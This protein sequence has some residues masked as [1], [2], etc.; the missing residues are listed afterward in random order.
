MENATLMAHRGANLMTRD[1]LAL[2]EAPAATDTHRP[3]P[4]ID[5]V[6]EIETTLALRRITIIEERFAVS[7]DGM[8]MFGLLKLET[9]FT[10]GNFAIGVR[11]SNDKSMRL[12]MVAGY[13]VFVCDNMAFVGEFQPVM[14]KH[15]KHVEITDTVTLGI[16]RIQRHFDP[17]QKQVT[18]WKDRA[19]PDQYAKAM[20]YDAFTSPK[21]RLPKQLLPVVDRHYF[22]PQYEEFAGRNM[23]SI[24]NAFTSAFK[25]LNPVRMFQDTAKLQPFLAQYQPPF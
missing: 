1:A 22:K 18:E 24:S 2:V 3:I 7:P 12:A 11:N 21:L 6:K 4:H 16:D 19:L 25:E 10:D 17:I 15:T 23:W 5:L 9:A 20:L 13:S 14:A 8:K